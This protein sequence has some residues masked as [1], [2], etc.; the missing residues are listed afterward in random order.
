[1]RVILC[2]QVGRRKPG[3]AVDVEE[4]I[5]RQW[6][7]DGIAMI[8]AADTPLKKRDLSLYN[9]CTPLTPAEIAAKVAI[10]DKKATMG[11]KQ[12]QTQTLPKD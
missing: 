5:A 2:K 9:N 1:M 11:P 4:A 7:K 10:E 12:T 3:T 8:G 6:A